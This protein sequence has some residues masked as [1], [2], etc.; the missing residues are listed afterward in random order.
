MSGLGDGNFKT[1]GRVI[2]AMA[3]GLHRERLLETGLQ[4][5]LEQGYSATG[6]G[7]VT[8]AAGIPK[9]SFYNYFRSKE[10]FAVAVLERYRE[11]E[12]ARLAE[13]LKP[14]E[15]S[16]LNRLRALFEHFAAGLRCAPAVHG[17]LAGRLAQELAGEH[18][19]FRQPLERTFRSLE[20]SLS[21]LLREAQEAAELD[22]REDPDR[23]AS[24]LVSAW[25][26]TLQR[27]KCGEG[28]E[29][30]RIFLDLVFEKLLR[31]PSAPSREPRPI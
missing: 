18:P 1:T 5:F 31:A 10:E 29:P 14:S 20:T 28:E 4:L 13:A 19:T 7:D 11:A 22:A 8:A 26:G 23:L 3:R 24:F 17:C 21:R 15:T 9:G 25:Q 2:P 16:P 12:V 6:V 27:A 30:V